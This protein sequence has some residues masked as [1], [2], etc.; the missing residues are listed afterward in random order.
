MSKNIENK[1]AVGPGPPREIVSSRY[2]EE[3]P[4]KQERTGISSRHGTIP[5]YWKTSGR[6][7][8][9]KDAPSFLAALKNPTHAVQSVKVGGEAWGCPVR[10]AGG[11]KRKLQ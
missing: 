11:R 3:V 2:G 7:T 5:A 1:M 6:G 9:K 8:V 10:G 4:V